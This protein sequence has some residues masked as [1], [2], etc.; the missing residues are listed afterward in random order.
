M[1]VKV[2]PIILPPAMYE[3]LER[4][5]R[6]QERDSV[7]QARWILKQALSTPKLKA[8]GVEPAR[9]ITAWAGQQETRHPLA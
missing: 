7:Q 5:A 3:R 1:R 6:A 4:D 2:L 9:T 8:A